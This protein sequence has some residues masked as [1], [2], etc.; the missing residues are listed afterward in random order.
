MWHIIKRELEYELPNGVSSDNFM[1]SL[2]RFREMIATD[3]K[4]VADTVIACIKQLLDD[5]ATAIQKEREAGQAFGS[6]I[7]M[8]KNILKDIPI[9]NVLNGQRI[10]RRILI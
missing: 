9:H 8:Y 3:K 7:T 1:P 5:K 10:S 2:Q 6:Y 4:L